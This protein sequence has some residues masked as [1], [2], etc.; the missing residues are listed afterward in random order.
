MS[1][2]KDVLKD[3][4]IEQTWFANKLTISYYMVNGYVQ[5]RQAPR[6]EVLC[7]ISKILEADVK[8]LL[9]SNIER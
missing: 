1:R 5:N 6:L 7:S 9:K 2:I 4:R 3:K 8:K